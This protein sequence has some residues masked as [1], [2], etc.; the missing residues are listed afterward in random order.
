MYNPNSNFVVRYT[1][2]EENLQQKT[3]EN[4]QY[5]DVADPYVTVSRGLSHSSCSNT[6]QF[7]VSVEP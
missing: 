6:M 5:D 1:S 3:K 2:K 7:K 4:R